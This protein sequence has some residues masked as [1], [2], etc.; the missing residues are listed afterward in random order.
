MAVISCTIGPHLASN[1]QD[2][3]RLFEVTSRHLTF[4][5]THII[6]PL[7]MCPPAPPCP[8]M[9]QDYFANSLADNKYVGVLYG[10]G[11]GSESKQPGG[12]DGHRYPH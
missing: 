12:G 4:L 2:C 11:E 1:G 5:T 8:P 10:L 7:F 3:E 9:T 6:L